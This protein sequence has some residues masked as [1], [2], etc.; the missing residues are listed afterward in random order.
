MRRRL[1]I[2]YSLRLSLV[3]CLATLLP[4]FVLYFLGEWGLVEATYSV[5]TGDERSNSRLT[6]PILP[7]T[8]RPNPDDSQ[9]SLIPP[10]NEGQIMNA[11]PE[12]ANLRLPAVY[13]EQTGD[14]WIESPSSNLVLTVP[15]FHLRIDL[16]AWIAIASLP[17]TSLI[18]GVLMSV[19]M[20]RHVTRPF[21]KLSLA[22][23]AITNRNLSVRVPAQGSKELHDLAATFNR[24]AAELENMQAIRRQLMA[25]VAHEL[26]TPLSV[27]DGNLRA[28]LDGVRPLDEEEIA[29]LQEQTQHLNRV[30]EDLREISLAESD[31]LPLSFGEVDLGKIMQDCSRHFEILAEEK[32]IDLQLECEQG[33]KHPNLDRH[34]IRQVLHN[35]LSNAFRH[36]PIGGRITLSAHRLE[37]P[38]TIII[39]VCD[40]GD[41][42]PANR[43]K[44]LF[45]RFHRPENHGVENGGSGLGL[46]IVKA[47]VEA[48]GGSVKAES[49]GP[50]QGSTFRIIFP[51]ESK[52]AV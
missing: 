37:D 47:I 12:S 19:W 45:D 50:G 18:L 27:L 9:R 8:N 28:L 23:Q 3:L 49:R 32:S 24:M 4:I 39:E 43:L 29:A 40:T 34:R 17:L 26:R 41:G 15:V 46:P 44:H 31:Q 30:I 16:P 48:Q 35:L 22:A 5:E 20:S 10:E 38:L 1:W 52:G 25:D 21:S 33:L 36:T 2:D 6:V 51:L 14:W 13:D 42:I 7:L 11:G